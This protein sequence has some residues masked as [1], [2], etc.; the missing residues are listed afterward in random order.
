MALIVEV[1]CNRQS[2]LFFNTFCVPTNF[3]LN[4]L[5]SAPP[6]CTGSPILRSHPLGGGAYERRWL[7]RSGV[8]IANWPPFSAPSFALDCICDAGWIGLALL[9]RFSVL[10]WGQ[11]SFW[12]ATVIT[13][14]ASAFPVV[15]HPLAFHR[16][17]PHP[18]RFCSQHTARAGSA[19]SPGARP[20]GLNQLSR[21]GSVDH[22]RQEPARY[23]VGH[24][25]RLEWFISEFLPLM[26][27]LAPHELRPARRLVIQSIRGRPPP[28]PVLV[29][30]SQELA[31]PSLPS[32]LCRAVPNRGRPKRWLLSTNHPAPISGSPRLPLGV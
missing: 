31:H 22:L 19:L 11:M 27:W 14:L 3:C 6:V 32:F 20:G 5:L 26:S 13:S 4:F 9:C 2:H 30:C 29:A 18:L 1:A 28:P 7:K 16:W 25:F 8:T 17:L 12:G 15:G 24:S 23:R 10:P 21:I